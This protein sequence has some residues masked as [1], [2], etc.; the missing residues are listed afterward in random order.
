[1]VLVQSPF[2]MSLVAS[3]TS[4]LCS[5][6]IDYRNRVSFGTNATV[7]LSFHF[8]PV[9]PS[10]PKSFIWLSLDQCWHGYFAKSFVTPQLIS[11]IIMASG[12]AII[13]KLIRT[14][15][16]II[17]PASNPKERRANNVLV[18]SLY[19]YPESHSKKTPDIT[20]KGGLKQWNEAMAWTLIKLK[21]QI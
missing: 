1:M 21:A 16:R 4:L 8:L 10:L 18:V 20:R 9:P 19:Y 15:H 5:S 6:P 13:L 3:Q 17:W 2:C 14:S 12:A 11:V 7:F